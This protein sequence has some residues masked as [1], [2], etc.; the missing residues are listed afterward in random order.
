MF[1]ACLHSHAELLNQRA[2]VIFNTSKNT[3]TGL[4][5]LRFKASLVTTNQ[6]TKSHSRLFYFPGYAEAI[7][8]GREF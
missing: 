1:K 8:A 3:I 6:M 2:P 5:M 4:F 7:Q